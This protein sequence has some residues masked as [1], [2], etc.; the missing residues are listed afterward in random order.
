MKRVKLL[1]LTMVIAVLTFA[2]CACG[3]GIE[4]SMHSNDAIGATQHTVVGGDIEPSGK[5]TIVCKDGHGVLNIN[6]EE[7]YVFA[8][9][10]YVGQE[11]SGLIYEETAT[12]ELQGND[13]LMA[14]AYNSSDFKLVFTYVA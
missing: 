8:A 11:Y 9:D 7:L 14:R 10:E 1:A 4:F 6:D 13:V 3:G 5:Y 2:L 12:L